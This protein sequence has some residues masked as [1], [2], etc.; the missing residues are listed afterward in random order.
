MPADCFLDSNI[1]LYILDDEHLK[2][3]K[4]KELLES[5]PTISTR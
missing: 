1:C 2:F 4:A 5:R 3:I